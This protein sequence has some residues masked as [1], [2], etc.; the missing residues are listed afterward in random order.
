MVGVGCQSR[1]QNYES[2]QLAKQDYRRVINPGPGMFT[3]LSEAAGT[4]SFRKH[5]CSQ[6]EGNPSPLYL[7]GMLGN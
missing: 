4:I 6:G 3:R 5:L 1:G 2:E 7:R